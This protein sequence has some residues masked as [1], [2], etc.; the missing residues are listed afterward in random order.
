MI[1]SGFTPQLSRQFAKLS[2]QGSA[3]LR[4]KQL[5]SLQSLWNPTLQ[6]VFISRLSFTTLFVTS[7]QRNTPVLLSL[8]AIGSCH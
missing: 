8:A 6:V 3:R 5:Q 4:D 1:Q 7:V 2:E